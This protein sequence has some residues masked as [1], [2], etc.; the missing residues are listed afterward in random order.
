MGSGTDDDLMFDEIF[1][2]SGACGVAII[3]LLLIFDEWAS[4]NSGFDK[5]LVCMT[6][7]EF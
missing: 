6:W 4:Y 7:T 1:A 3:V 2:C 5:E